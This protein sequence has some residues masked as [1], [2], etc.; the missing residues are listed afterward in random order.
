MNVQSVTSYNQRSFSGY[1]DLSSEIINSDR[2][3]LI[4]IAE[5]FFNASEKELQDITKSDK[6]AYRLIKEAVDMVATRKRCYIADGSSFCKKR[7]EEMD[8]K[9]SQRDLNYLA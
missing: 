7:A 3:G 9:A 2:K 1:R 6:S 5:Y 4:N 8:K